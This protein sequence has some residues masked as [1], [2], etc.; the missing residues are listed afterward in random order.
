MKSLRAVSINNR[1]W[2]MLACALA[3]ILVIGAKSLHSVYQTMF[4]AEHVAKEEQV[5]SWVNSGYGLLEKYYQ[6]VQSGQVSEAEAKAAALSSLQALW[7]EDYYYWINDG[8]PTLL[9]N[10]AA[11]HLEGTDVGGFVDKGGKRLF[12]EIIITANSNP[13]GG[14]LEYYWPKP[15]ATEP[16]T[17]ISFVRKFD[18]WNWYIGSGA[19]PQDIAPRFNEFALSAGVLALVFMALLM[20]V[21]R[22]ISASIAQPVEQISK[23]M[24]DIAQGNGDLTQR[25][26]VAGNDELTALS[27]SFNQFVDQIHQIIRESQQATG[28]VANLGHDL[29]TLSSSTKSL[30]LQQ[31]RESDSV[32]AG[33]AQMSQTIHE[34]AL[35]AEQAAATVKTVESSAQSGLQTMQETQNRIAD[36][37]RQIQSSRES[38]QNLRGE[39]ESIGTVLDVIRGIAEQTNL[40]ALNAAIEAARA[41]EQ[42]RGFAVVAD[43]V[44][45]LASRTQE[46]T[47][48]IHRTISRLQEQAEATVQ[49]M[50]HSALH[51]Q[52]T[53]ALSESAREGITKI[54]DA[55][56]SL[57]DM[58]ASV[59]SAVEQ[60][61]KAADDISRSISHIAVSSGSIDENMAR[62]DDNGSRLANCSANLSQ[63]I[64]R[65]RV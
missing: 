2:L 15:G 45:T 23:T 8:Q 64:S 20:V 6:Q 30:T 43:E 65:F 14:L 46:S 56:E 51:S 27:A 48:E 16:S 13:A 38:I 10:P 39:T 1:L 18:P 63:L 32:A 42:G 41:G 44:R 9:L 60:Q 52:E 29:V 26:P 21:S 58:N 7:H 53:S 54:S 19:Y 59:A 50:E 47:E 62:S 61:S 3:C 5:R 11:P 31:M 25:I 57:T 36:L 28:E 22:I 17:K 12:Q 33:A 49:S 55:I 24:K 4:D 40:L 35:K 34:V 37:A